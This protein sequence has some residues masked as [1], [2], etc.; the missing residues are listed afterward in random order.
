MHICQAKVTAL[1]AGVVDSEQVQ[2]RGVGAIFF[3]VVAPALQWMPWAEM[4]ELK[5]KQLSYLRNLHSSRAYQQL[6][7]R[8]FVHQQQMAQ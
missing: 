2:Q 4:L 8:F 5:S 6:L 1:E 3:G 7:G